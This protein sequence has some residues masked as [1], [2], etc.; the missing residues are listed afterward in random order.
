MRKGKCVTCRGDGRNEQPKLTVGESEQRGMRGIIRRVTT[1]A[2]VY[3][4]LLGVGMGS[5]LVS[6][7]RRARWGWSSPNWYR[8]VTNM[9]L[10]NAA[11]RLSPTSGTTGTRTGRCRSM[12]TDQAMS[13]I[14]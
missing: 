13:P 2:T 6:A 12:T 1:L 4:H 14:R 7:R 10:T 11:D 5:N 8:T 9:R 3:D